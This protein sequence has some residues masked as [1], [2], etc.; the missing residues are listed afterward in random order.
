MGRKKIEFTKEQDER[1]SQLVSEGYSLNQILPIINGEFNSSFSR[2][3]I[4]RRIK[5]LGIDRT[6]CNTVKEN[7]TIHNRKLANR[8]EELREWKRRQ[9]NDHDTITEQYIANEMGIC[10]KTLNKMYEQF[11][12]PK[13]LQP[14]NRPD[15]YF[16]VKELVDCT[17]L[18]KDARE[19]IY[20]EILKRKPKDMRVERDVVIRTEP[21]TIKYSYRR[22]DDKW[23]EKSV[24]M[25]GVDLKVDFYFPDYKTGFF[26]YDF[27]YFRSLCKKNLDYSVK[28]YWWGDYLRK[29][30]NGIK[31]MAAIP[32]KTLEDRYVNIEFMAKSMIDRAISGEYNHWKYAESLK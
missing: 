29:F 23:V 14:S 11:D 13:R 7:I 19:A 2:S 8:V 18:N 25:D 4:D 3:G 6:I 30:K 22:D 26:Y 17:R 5:T 16:D 12:I 20:S 27:F 9:A 15:I 24:D 31:L 1:I 32:I 28:P 10:V 21:M